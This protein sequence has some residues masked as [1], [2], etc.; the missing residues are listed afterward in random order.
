[1]FAF[2]SPLMQC[3]TLMVTLMQTQISSVNKALRPIVARSRII[4]GLTKEELQQNILKRRITLKCRWFLKRMTVSVRFHC[5]SEDLFGLGQSDLDCLC[6]SV[7]FLFSCFIT[8]FWS[9][10]V[11]K[12][13]FVVACCYANC[14]YYSYSCCVEQ[15]K[16]FTG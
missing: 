10:H 6:F 4:G 16:L 14:G 2:A 7:S 15:F 1:M 3:S 9:R 5:I 11:L 12:C 8:W 13:L